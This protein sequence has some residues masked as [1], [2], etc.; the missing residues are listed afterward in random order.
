L[1]NVL[2][3]LEDP[4]ADLHHPAYAKLLLDAAERVAPRGTP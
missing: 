1:R 3:V 4:A 2:L